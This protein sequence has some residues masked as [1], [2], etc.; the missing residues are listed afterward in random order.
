V[1]INQEQ[2]ERTV[3]LLYNIPEELRRR[4][5]WVVWKLE[6]RGGKNTKVPYIAGG[7]GM[8]STVDMMTW[9]TFEE[10]ADA[11]RSSGRYDGAGYV[12]STGD[13]YSAVDLDDCRN[14]ETGEIEEWARRVVEDLGGYTEV[15]QSG[16]GLHVVVRGKA[17]NKKR[18]K[19][20][21]YSSE[22]YFAMTGRAL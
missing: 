9:R 18:G 15:S 19:V 17:P 2:Q 20:E 22:R 5:Q 1:S 7:V 13:P 21:A 11:L 8:A 14:P 10:A 3:D 6:K 16:A 12:F 4:P